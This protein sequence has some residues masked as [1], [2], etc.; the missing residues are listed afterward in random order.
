MPRMNK[1]PLFHNQDASQRR[2]L[3]RPPASRLW[4]LFLMGL[5]LLPGCVQPAPA[6]PGPTNTAPVHD[7]FDTPNAPAPEITP[8]PIGPTATPIFLPTFTPTPGAT[9]RPLQQTTNVLILGSDRRGGK[10]T[11]RTDV[12][13]LVAVDFAQ[14]RVGVISIPRDLFVQIPG[15]GRERINTADVYGER[16]QPGKGI[17]L[18]KQTIVDNLGLP[19]D[20]Y[21]RVDFGGFE[22][23][24]DTLGGITVTMDCPLHERWADPAAPGGVVVL[25]YEPGDHALDGQHALWY[26]RTR[27]R[28]NDLDRARRQQRVLL[29][30][31]GR[32]EEVNLLPKVPDLFSALR[33]NVDT[34]LNL[35]DVLALAR[36]GIELK[37]EDIHSRVFDFQMA[38]PYTTAG[39][40]A[41]LLP[42]KAAIR[43][44]FDQIWD[45]PDV[46]TSTDRQQN[47]P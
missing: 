26:V 37:R 38:Q 10:G 43:K 22:Q 45:A 46:I 35:L 25:D 27:R 7:A 6:P 36:L 12:M 5:I 40:A 28:G 3:R 17:N 30:L 44:A 16:Q 14:K 18:V 33:E 19:V 34:D 42:N 11:G 2:R 32:A 39:G 21:V 13:I 23:I 31:K 15:V 29:A 9:P 1:S 20:N 24:V 4:A 47:C 41:V 8:T